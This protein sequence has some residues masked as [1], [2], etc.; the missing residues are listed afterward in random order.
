MKKII[1]LFVALFFMIS[2]A[3]AKNITII[4]KGSDD[5]VNY[6]RVAESHSLFQSSLSCLDPGSIG[7]GWT[8]VPNIG[9]LPS[10][11]I[12]DYVMLQIDA[13][14]L[15]GNVNFN[16]VVYVNWS[17]DPDTDE[18]VILMDDGKN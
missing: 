11:K 2:S 4:R 14:N 17:Y 16:G 15:N 1:L 10:N 5:G 3:D 18:L 13:G 6:N 7:C 8:Q 12:E 9:G